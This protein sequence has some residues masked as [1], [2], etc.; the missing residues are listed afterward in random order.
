MM[1]RARHAARL[2]FAAL[3][4]AFLAAP[5]AQAQDEGQVT[6]LKEGLSLMRE[7]KW[8]AALIAAGPEGSV[9]Y[10]I[11]EWNRLRA[12]QGSFAEALAFL[13]RRPD[14]PG[15]DYLRQQAERTIPENATRADVLAF[16]ENH[17]PQTG[18]GA[19]RFA[20][21]LWE[22]GE[23]DRA[24]QTARNAWTTLSLT[25]EEEEQFMLVWPKTLAD[26]HW[27]RTD[28]LLWEGHMKEAERQMPR[29]TDGQKA[30]VRARVG[31][32]DAVD[33]VDA[34]IAAVPEGLAEDPG[35]AY[36]RMQWRA[37]KGRGD[38]AIAL[39]LERSTSPES[40]GRPDAWGY[41][42]RMLARGAMREGKTDLA[43]RLV[44]NHHIAEGWNREDSEWL[45]G[46]LALRFRD[47]AQTALRHFQAFRATVDTPI[48]LGRAGYWEGRAYEALGQ[49]EQAR[50]AYAFGGEHQ[51]AFYGLLAAE[52]A[53]L[54]MDPQLAGT[55]A[56]PDY[57][58]ASFWD[59][60]IME[61]ARLTW[62]AGERYLTERMVVHLS[63]RLDRAETGA[64]GDWLMEV[65]AHHEALKMAKH[66]IN[67]DQVIEAAYFPVPDIGRGNPAVPRVLELSIARR[68]SEFDPAVTSHAGAMGLM[69]LMPGTAKDMA[70]R[71]GVA[72][73]KSKLTGDMHYNTRLG[74]EYLA[75]LMERYGNNPVLIAVA[76]NA[77]PGRANR[78]QELYGDPRDP[79]V[80]VVDWIEMIP[81]N[82]TQTYV[83][84]VSE[85]LPI[86][87]ARQTG[88]TGPLTF[89]AMLKRR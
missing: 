17:A 19:L 66:A 75:W 67:Y 51:T 29:L 52:K 7:G 5:L 41:Q 32:H 47:D 73:E 34:L 78:W 13:E 6:A 53:G 65:G 50:A 81:F 46:Y 55:E 82:E 30:L 2:L 77:G 4:A 40:L 68:E 14:W 89:E 60:P 74:S 28:N 43:Y 61:A 37:R 18:T 79:E 45:A 69:Q 15:E 38:D 21:A 58:S 54:D 36:E 26:Y 9:A 87:E 31:L 8:D 24:M 71:V 76:Y 3:L 85:S 33:G 23:K 20:R 44:A 35:L 42:R 83:M 27:A 64:L 56:F 39:I 25:P 62:A 88:K 22:T 86:Y 1:R 49:P 10:D 16:F 84:R 70:T 11:V 80:D 63:E 72:Y 59:M 57:R 12:R 48:S